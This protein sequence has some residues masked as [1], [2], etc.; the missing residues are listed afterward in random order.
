M[1]SI[2]L[3]T[4]TDTVLDGKIW[5]LCPLYWIGLHYVGTELNT[6][7]SGT[8]LALYQGPRREDA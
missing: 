8:Q 6:L 4:D 5:P 1:G 7:A 3:C 2:Q